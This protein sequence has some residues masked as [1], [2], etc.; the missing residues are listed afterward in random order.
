[1]VIIVEGT[2]ASLA[3]GLVLGIALGSVVV[4]SIGYAQN[5]KERE[6]GNNR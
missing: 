5:R 1:M 4:F 3:T 2:I 6:S